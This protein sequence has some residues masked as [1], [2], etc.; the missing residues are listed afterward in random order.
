MQQVINHLS[1][2]NVV[3]DRKSHQSHEENKTGTEC[4]FLC[5]SVQGTPHHRLIREE[6]EMATV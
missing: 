1:P 6:D 2:Y 3:D 5:C 4:P